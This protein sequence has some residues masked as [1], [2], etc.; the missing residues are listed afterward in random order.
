M[1]CEKE[2]CARWRSFLFASYKNQ[3]AILTDMAH[4]LITQTYN[5]SKQN[6]TQI[7]SCWQKWLLLIFVPVI[8]ANIILVYRLHYNNQET[9]QFQLFLNYISIQDQINI[10]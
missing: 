3:V 8:F 7:F 4:N 1:S 9:I 10:C 5:L 2:N 6:K